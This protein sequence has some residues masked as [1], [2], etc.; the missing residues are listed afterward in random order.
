MGAMP[1]LLL[2]LLSQ[3]LACCPVPGL[4]RNSVLLETDQEFRVGAAVTYACREGFHL[5]GSSQRVC[6][7]NGSWAPPS[8]PYCLA[9]IAD[10]EAVSQS[11]SQPRG[12][13]KLA[14]D[15][16]PTTCSATIRQLSPWFV[17][18]LHDS[19]P[20]GV[21]KIQLPAPT[22][23]NP[24]R[25]TVRVGNSSSGFGNPVCTA[26]NKETASGRPIYLPCVSREGG[27]YLSVHLEEF[28][29]LSICEMVVYSEYADPATMDENRGDATT[30]TPQTPVTRLP[31]TKRGPLG[32]KGLTGVGIGAFVLLAPIC[33]CCWCRKCGKC[34]CCCKKRRSDGELAGTA[35]SVFVLNE[36]PR[37][38][39]YT[40][41]WD[42]LDR[43]GT[44]PTGF[45]GGTTRLQSVA[46]V[47]S[48]A[49]SVRDTDVGWF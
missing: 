25:L 20:I 35:N 45:S 26:F 46:T 49:G 11:T 42:E 2:S 40:R 34:C 6:L 43:S 32:M 28:G 44:V 29:S 27:R 5:L 30:V 1:L 21:V 18:D 41:S 24:G 33:C 36:N 7:K 23:P 17:V 13:A 8:L 3:Q 38:F 47:T 9:D 12:D 16:N 48:P 19:F 22:D 10:P 15:G 31:E 37:V 4:P 39:G 14:L